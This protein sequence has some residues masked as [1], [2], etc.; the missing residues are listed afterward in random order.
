MKY[1]DKSS[2]DAVAGLQLG[3]NTPFRFRCHSG[4]SCYNQCCR[5]LN[6]FLY[7]Y[8][9][10]RLKKA[11]K[12]T[13]DTFLDTYTD[14]V[15]RPSNHFPDVLLTM[16]DNSERTCPFLVSEGCSV[17]ADRPGTCRMFP[18]E[19]GIYYDE[20]SNAARRLFFFRPPDFCLGQ[21]EK[22]QWQSRS[23]I[24]NQNSHTHHQM[25]IEWSDLKRRFQTDPWGSEGPNGRKSKM[26]FMAL[27][28]TDRFREFVFNSSFLSRYRV[29]R[30]VLKQIRTKDR[31]LLLFAFDWVKAFLW[32]IPSRKIL[33]R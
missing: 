21:H 2:I 30:S 29:P 10:I 24:K 26:A 28:N 11:L 1:I 5:N 7:P 23:W 9:V 6:L 16:A 31:E 27:Y 3:D 33:L 15:L 18:V 20:R 13:S 32:G 19:P 4:L 17:Y 8:D 22:Q 14:L 12:M 25:A